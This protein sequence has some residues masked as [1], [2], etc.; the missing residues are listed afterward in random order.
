MMRGTML[1]SHAKAH[2]CRVFPHF[3]AFSRVFPQESC[4]QKLCL[5]LQKEVIQAQRL[6]IP[7]RRNTLLPVMATM[8]VVILT[9]PVF[10]AYSGSQIQLNSVGDAKKRPPLRSGQSGSPVVLKY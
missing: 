7:D 9:R 8:I 4:V 5:L 1:V 10:R 6:R 2:L 3:S